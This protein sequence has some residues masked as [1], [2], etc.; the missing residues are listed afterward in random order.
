MGGSTNREGRVE[1]CVDGQRGTVCGEGW[2]DTEA[3]LVCARLGFPRQ[4]NRLHYSDLLEPLCVII[5][6]T[7]ATIHPFG[8]SSVQPIY[9]LTCSHP[10]SDPPDCTA[11]PAPDSCD[12]SMDVGVRCLSHKEVCVSMH[13]KSETTATMSVTEFTPQEPSSTLS[14]SSSLSESVIQSVLKAHR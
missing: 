2:G 4:S 12:H 11:T 5:L 1:V 3:G 8:E 14:I 9:N 10:E 7:D 13:D 6:L